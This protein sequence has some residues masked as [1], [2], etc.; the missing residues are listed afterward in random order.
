M[1]LS[2]L[3]IEPFE[4][5]LL[6][7]VS[8]KTHSTILLTPNLTLSFS[9]LL[10]WF[11]IKYSLFCSPRH[12]FMLKLTLFRTIDPSQF[13]WRSVICPLVSIIP[14]TSRLDDDSNE[15]GDL[16]TGTAKR[17]RQTVYSGHVKTGDEPSI[18]VGK[19]SACGLDTP[20]LFTC[21]KCRRLFHENCDSFR[22]DQD[23]TGICC[24]CLTTV[25]LSQYLN[26][27]SF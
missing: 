20:P 17:S 6:Y 2:I 26:I 13:R 18:H 14:F 12:Y 8:T 9:S 21:L 27:R 23:S 25:F 11:H 4:N 19:C 3:Y 16:S 10:M 15:E 24:A 7:F 1:C 5:W 22:I